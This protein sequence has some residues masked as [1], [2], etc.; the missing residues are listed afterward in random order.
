VLAKAQTGIV[1]AGDVLCMM[2]GV[3]DGLDGLAYRFDQDTIESLG[4]TDVD[5]QTIIAGFAEELQK[6]EE[7]IS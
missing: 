1:H 3:N 7:L 2:M 6:I 4:M 5:L